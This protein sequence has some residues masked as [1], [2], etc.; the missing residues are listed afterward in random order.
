M[1]VVGLQSDPA[2]E[3]RASDPTENIIIYVFVWVIVVAVNVA[4]T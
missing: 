4:L 2:T 3:T 1:F